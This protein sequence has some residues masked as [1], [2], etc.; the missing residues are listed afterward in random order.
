M[1]WITSIRQLNPDA[2]L[3]VGIERPWGDAL[4]FKS[5][6]PPLE[7]AE[8][9]LPRR[10]F[11]G[12]LVSFNYGLSPEATLPRDAF[13]L[14]TLLDQWSSLGKPLY[15][16]FSVPS[17]P[18]TYDPLWETA[19]GKSEPIC[20][21]HTQQENVHRTFLSL[22]TRKTIRGIF[23]NCF[24]DLAS[25]TDQIL[26]EDGADDLRDDTKS[27][28]E[29][30]D[31]EETTRRPERKGHKEPADSGGIAISAADEPV[32]EGEPDIPSAKILEPEEVE[33]ASLDDSHDHMSLSFP[34]SGLVNADGTPK[35]AFRKLAALR[36][37]YLG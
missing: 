5:E 10:V 20:T 2:L 14:N 29:L 7:L 34:H 1:K 13:E 33:I 8:T 22:L 11:S 36:G 17:A 25:D 27:F 35:S 19:E 31:D 30:N 12:F 21:P 6:I 23:W 9:L 37:A 32:T 24:D 15:F 28:S 16:S 4:R 3:L 26:A 18:T